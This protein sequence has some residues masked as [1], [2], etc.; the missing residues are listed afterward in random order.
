M[1]ETERIKNIVITG[2]FAAIICVLSIFPLPFNIMGVPAT[3]QTFAVGLTGYVLG[4]K[5]GTMATFIYILL[6]AVGI[7]V[8]NGG[9]GGIGV[10]FNITGGF[11]YGF[12]I[13]AFMCGMAYKTK[14]IILKIIYSLAGLVICHLCGIIQ[15]SFITGNDFIK[16]ML[17]V[18]VPYLAKDI[19][20]LLAAYFVAAAIRKSKIIN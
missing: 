1:S 5:K 10:I 3:L 12:L 19:I 17:L 13:L 9:K 6:G 18:T 14:K 16:S 2:L 15:F 4:E 8:F 11:I 20:T 7:P